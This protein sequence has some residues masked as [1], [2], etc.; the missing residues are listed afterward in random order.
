MTKKIF[1]LLILTAIS[2]SIF[3]A[4]RFPIKSEIFPKN[5]IKNV[6]IRVSF[7]NVEIEETYG[8]EILVEIYGNNLKRIPNVK[9]EGDALVIEAKNEL[10]RIPKATVCNVKIYVPRDAKFENVNVASASADIEIEKLVAENL[11]FQSASGDIECKNLAADKKIKA[12]SVSGKV[13]IEEARSKEIA[14]GSTSGKISLD[15]ISS[16]TLTI[17]SI[18]GKIDAENFYGE[19]IEA[20]TTSGDIEIE[21]LNAEYFSFNSVSGKIDAELKNVPVAS[22]KIETTSGS[23]QLFA[24]RG[25]GFTLTVSSN[26][27]TFRDRIN[28]N[29]LVPR[30][31]FSQKYYGGGADVFIK[32][33]SGGILLEN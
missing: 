20:N 2:F 19:Y 24:P 28:D 12:S 7:E 9:K 18:S 13:E 14:V 8:N 22:S 27:G 6:D 32:T 33:T 11:N 25:K 21:N 29:R 10:F 23:V 5:Q 15:K 3:A 26:S 1:S 30:S 31:E 4:G 16:D 17:K